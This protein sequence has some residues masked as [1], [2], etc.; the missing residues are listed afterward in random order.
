M[1][2]ER[3]SATCQECDDKKLPSALVSSS[4]KWDNKSKCLMEL[5]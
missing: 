4:T 2:L 5:L 3:D 1:K